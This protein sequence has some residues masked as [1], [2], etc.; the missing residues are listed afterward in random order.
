VTR[1]ATI[2]TLIL[3]LAVAGGARSASVG[4]PPANQARAFLE[5]VLAWPKA[6]DRMRTLIGEL[7]HADYARRE[8]ATQALIALGE[9]ALPSVEEAARSDDPEVRCRARDIL[10]ALRT[11][12]PDQS[13]EMTQA[14]DALAAA[15]D[16]WLMPALLHLLAHPRSDARYAAEYGLRRL[17]GRC[18]GYN[19]AATKADRD[20]AAARWHQWWKEAEKSFAFDPP[21]AAPQK[22]AG[23][24]V[25]HQCQMEDR[26]FDLQGRV[27]WSRRKDQP[28]VVTPLENGHLLLASQKP[29]PGHMEQIATNGLV[30]WTSE[31]FELKGYRT[32]GRRLANGNTLVAHAAA[33]EV[34]EFDPLGKLVWRARVLNPAS[35]ERLPSGGTLV[36]IG[37]SHSPVVVLSRAGRFV[38]R[39]PDLRAPIH[40]VALPNG[41]VLVAESFA[42]RVVELDRHGET[43]W[44]YRCKGTPSCALRLPDGTTVLLD[45]EEG[46]LHVDREGKPIRTLDRTVRVGKLALVPAVPAWEEQFR[47]EGAAEPREKEQP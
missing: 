47:R 23:I 21:A 17:T 42:Q 9:P 1:N 22:V 24:F 29:S 2:P 20:A 4:P 7:G 27:V 5:D 35:A 44:E 45:S 38:W 14:L 41:R 31:P 25:S 39:T 34:V 43:V 26:V 8:Q 32:D 11:H 28:T 15:K 37:S 40:A 16:P 12:P 18:F 10:D 46:L 33:D 30:V 36:A 6:T 3:L 19:A 13:W